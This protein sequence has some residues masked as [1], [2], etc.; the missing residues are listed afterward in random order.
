M[1]EV[2]QLT[3]QFGNLKAVDNLSFKAQPGRVTGF[4][5]PNG[6]GK[7][8][9]LRS[10]LAL[11][12]PNTGQVTFGGRTYSQIKQPAR[13]V[14]VTL[15]ASSFHPG[16]SGLNH[17]L[18]LAPGIGVKKARCLQLLEQ[19]GLSN[20]INKRVGEYSMGMR[21]RLALAGAMLGDPEFLM[22]DEPTNG[23]D[24]EGIVWVRQLLRSLAGEGRT[25]LISSHLLGEVENTVDDV[26]VI[27]HGR[28][29]HA[30][31]LEDM[32]RLAVPRTLVRPADPAAFAQLAA[33][34]GWQVPDA[35]GGH[36]TI[37]GP[38]AAAIGQA[39]FAA[40]LELHQLATLRQGLEQLYFAMTE[41]SKPR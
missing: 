18:T 37:E 24:P 16:R 40:G 7:T 32:R 35:Q 10:A 8:T 4:L 26:V 31:S 5:G 23:L 28:L 9:T 39:A 21:G 15:E 17:L 2:A 3:K 22:F 11:I 34:S 12:R 41:G 6:A 13:H 38:E 29:V 14:G 25:V 20:A 1:I 36:F 30:S 33:A 27:T 19:V